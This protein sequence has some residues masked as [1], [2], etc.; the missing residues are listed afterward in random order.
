[1]NPTN[2]GAVPDRYNVPDMA[3]DDVI[4]IDSADIEAEF[5]EPAPDVGLPGTMNRLMQ[6]IQSENIAELLSE[7]KLL[8]I[9]KRVTDDYDTDKVVKVIKAQLKPKPAP[10]TTGNKAATA[11]AG[12]Q[13]K[14][15]AS[16]AATRSAGTRV[17]PEIEGCATPSFRASAD[18]PPAACNAACKPA[19]L[20]TLRSAVTPPF[21][22]SVTP[23]AISAKPEGAK[24]LD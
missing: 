3:T 21:S 24:K 2:P 10:N 15:A 14:P 22:L 8:E 12:Q 13:G 23:A 6:F 5:E 1:M 9:G 11:A 19:S 17:Q 7:H 20:I 18:A 16:T 4:D